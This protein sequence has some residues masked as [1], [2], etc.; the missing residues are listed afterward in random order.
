MTRTRFSRFAFLLVAAILLT[1]SVASAAGPYQFFSLTPC[2]IADT[3]TTTI[4]NFPFPY[5]PPAL[6]AGLPRSFPITGQCGIP[7][8]AKAVAL[9]VTV[10]TPSMEG[11]I[12]IW[13]SNQS[14]PGVS[15]INFAAGEPAIANG[16]IVPLAL[17]Q[18]GNT[19]AGN[20]ISVVY[21]TAVAGGN[22]QLILDVTGF[23]K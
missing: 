1:V 2:R 20:Q 6:T 12:K 7:S 9:N 11:F 8:D 13:P 5:G 4:P 3:R 21:G 15:T 10:A 14:M 19:L 17:D 22:T 23:F 18:Q 16:A